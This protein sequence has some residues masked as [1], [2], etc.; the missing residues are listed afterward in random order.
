[1]NRI[2]RLLITSGHS[3]GMILP[4]MLVIMLVT[5]TVILSLSGLALAQMNRADRGVMV[6]NA[7]LV[8]EAGAE[9]TLRELNIDSGF[10]GYQT[11]EV[12]AE[13][14]IQGRTTY[15]T[16]IAEGSLSNEKIITSTG[17]VYMPANSTQPEVV[18]SIRLV[19]V[20][21]T[22]DDYAIRTGPG[23]LIMTNN[24]TVANGDVYVNGYISMSN[25][26]LIGS[27]NNP[28]NVFVAH[29]FCPDPPDDT[30][31]SQCTS[32][33]S[34]SISN[35]AAI[36]GEVHATNQTDGSGMYSPGLI[37]NSSA[38]PTSLP[39]Y[40]RQA[41]KDAISNTMSSAEA[42][43]TSNSTTK[44]W[45]ANTH[46]TGDVDIRKSCTVLLQGDVWIDG[47]LAARN[48]GTIEVDDSLNEHPVIMVDG[49]SGVEMRNSSQILTNVNGIGL[50]IITFYS[51]A[52]CSPDCEDV[53][54][55]DLYNS[56]NTT[57]ISMNNSSLAAGT[58][59]YARWSRID[60]GN[61]GSIGSVL[62]Q[63]I[64]LSN[65]GNITF[66]EELSS[67]ESVWS[68][69]NYQQIFN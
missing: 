22:T 41:Q 27:A 64:I 60:I 31:P 48:S 40:D 45:P 30:F 19:V 55:V 38:E 23:G 65:T 39:D 24:A 43:C 53:T 7:L 52:N 15:Q 26:A 4:T 21:T 2:T 14:N 35:F 34:I 25:N 8:A 58:R 44:I 42:S 10:V 62:G 13:D 9:K 49:S 16:T 12:L 17:R 50:E 36:Y 29:M 47:S 37:E 18:R 54:G 28:S 11:E 1:M 69:K 61:S 57:T 51:T 59:L 67:G 56:Q 6:A 66:G 68:I 20:G 3:E 63:T 33:Q 32:G 46:I 5:L